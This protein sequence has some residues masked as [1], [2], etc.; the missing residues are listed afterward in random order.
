MSAR[1][2]SLAP[3]ALAGLL[4][5]CDPGPPEPLPPH[6]FA[7]GVFGDGPYYVWEQGRFRRAL[8][9]MERWDVEWLIHVGDILWYPCSEAAYRERR[10][11]LDGLDIPVVYTPGDNEWTDCH[12]ERPGGHDPL[13][14]LAVLRRTFFPD[15]SRSLGSVPLAVVSQARDTAFAEFVENVR[16]KRGGLVFATVHVVG[17]SNG[18]DPFEGRTPD[19]DAEVARRTR[20]AV[21]WIRETFVVARRDSAAGLVIALHAEMGLAPEQPDPV[22]GPIVAELQSQVSRF[23][24]PTVLIHGDNHELIVNHPLTDSA[25]RTLRRFTRLETYG[26]PDIGWVRVV[27]DTVTGAVTTEPR[28]MRGWW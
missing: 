5:G 23:E 6:A 15:P 9:D 13:D 7:F 17:S 21:A 1:S 14:R 27:V 12:E 3:V 24:S 8:Q 25:G 16:W 10:D 19:H 20:A 2:W 22:Y 4:L 26:S 18:M 28:L 11:Q